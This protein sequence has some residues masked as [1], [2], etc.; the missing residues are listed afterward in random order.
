MLMKVLAYKQ[1]KSKVNFTSIKNRLSKEIISEKILQEV[2]LQ[3]TPQAIATSANTIVLAGMNKLYFINEK[4]LKV[5][6]TLPLD[7]SKYGSLSNLCC[8]DDASTILVHNY[9]RVVVV[10]RLNG[11]KYQVSEVIEVIAEE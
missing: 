3:E 9:D 1:K 5:E 10:K 11:R 4:S 6:D 2:K 7:N 8:N